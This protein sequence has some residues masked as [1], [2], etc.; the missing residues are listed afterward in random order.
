MT[1]ENTIHFIL[2]G[3]T[4]DSFYDGTKDTVLAREHSIVPDYIKSAKLYEDF[5][6]TEVCMKDSRN[7]SMEDLGNILTNSQYTEIVTIKDISG[8]RN[9][10]LL[11]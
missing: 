3:G 2:T 9:A 4:L 6:F 11:L 1:K 5:D 7:L 10:I 8:K